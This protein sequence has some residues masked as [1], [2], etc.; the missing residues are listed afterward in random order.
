VPSPDPGGA[1]YLNGVAAVA[2]DDVW[3][4]G[5]YGARPGSRT[6]TLAEHWDG[7]SWRVVPSPGVAKE[8]SELLAVAAVS[9]TDVWAVGF[10][11]A[12]GSQ[13]QPL[14]EHW[15]GRTWTIAPP[16]EP[17]P[18]P[19]TLTSVSVRSAS[20]VWAVG[21]RQ[22]ER[23]R[24]LIEH[25]DGEVWSV[26]RSPSPGDPDNDLFGVVA[27]KPNV[28]WAVGDFDRLA[29]SPQT[30]TLVERWDGTSWS[31]VQS[32]NVDPIDNWLY[33]ADAVGPRQVWAV[34]NEGG[35]DARTLTERWNGSGWSVVPS[36]GVD[37]A[38]NSL[39]SV[40]A[41]GPGDVWAAGF[42]RDLSTGF[43]HALAERW[44]GTAWSLTDTVDSDQANN[45]LA[46]VSAAGGAVWVVGIRF[47]GGQDRI[48]TLIER[49]CPP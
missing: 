49:V 13:N 32:P 24:T 4:V 1:N 21:T 3:A 48:R 26:V 20:D 42:W 7:S 47:E 29:Y 2:A 25:W 34:G 18:G 31:K 37:Q 22:G 38:G 27:L 40:A 19:A 43:E 41:I 12:E 45:A 15:D 35:I 17:A 39:R 30:R 8:T 6:R 9:A 10:H 14:A 46:G 33:A 36:A 44:N 16:P 5:A 11:R 23:S 28:A